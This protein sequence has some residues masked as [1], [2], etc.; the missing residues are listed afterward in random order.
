MPPEILAL[1]EKPLSLMAILFVGGIMG[2][3]VEQIT[4]KRRRE[5]WKRRN[6][7]RS[8]QFTR[9]SSPAVV[10][11]TP[12]HDL[13]AK[14]PDATDQLRTVMAADFA[15]RPLL[16]K[17]E[18]RLFRE[19][20]RMVVS[21]NPGWQVMA[22]VCVGEF[23]RSKD[24]DAFRCINAK[25]VDLLLM[26]GACNARHAIE[27]QGSG[28]HL[29]GNAAAARDAV[30]KEALRKAAIGYHEVVAGVTTPTE[31]RRLVEKLVPELRA[32]AKRGPLPTCCPSN[33]R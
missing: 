16:N 33:A 9:N 6:G 30:K 15:V 12:G 23:L 28:H 10:R 22:Q 31:L 18:A 19:L 25:R 8:K 17:A 1:L 24:A 11:D 32:A 13:I 3:L 29:A 21:R 27:Y 2:M 4:S 20:D 5:A 14:A 7:S 26:D